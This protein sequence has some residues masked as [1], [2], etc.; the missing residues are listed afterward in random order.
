VFCHNTSCLISWYPVRLIGITGYLTSNYS[1][2]NLSASDWLLIPHALW[3]SGGSQ[4]IIKLNVQDLFSTESFSH[5]RRP[6]RIQLNFKS[7]VF[8][9]WAYLKQKLTKTRTVGFM[10]WLSNYGDWKIIKCALIFKPQIQKRI[11]GGRF[12]LLLKIMLIILM[13]E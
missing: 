6:N 3:T 8:P 13:F 12:V 7:K 2:V 11:R 9:Y 5:D 1:I 10:K 4:I